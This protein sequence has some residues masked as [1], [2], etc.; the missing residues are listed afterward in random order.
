MHSGATTVDVTIERVGHKIRVT[1][2]D[3]G[4]PFDPLSYEP[5][6]RDFEDWDVGGLGIG[7]VRQICDDVAYSHADGRNVLTLTF[8][9]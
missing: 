6:E 8:Q 4:V 1:L 9:G 3:D 5:V 7:F 2:S